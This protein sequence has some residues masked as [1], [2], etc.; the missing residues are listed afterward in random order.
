MYV[1]RASTR[2]C[3]SEKKRSTINVDS[4]AI[5]GS[6]KRNR[7]WITSA[8]LPYPTAIGR[9]NASCLPRT[10]RSRNMGLIS[11]VFSP[12]SIAFSTCVLNSLVKPARYSARN[13]A[14]VLRLCNVQSLPHRL[15]LN[16]SRFMNHL[17]QIIFF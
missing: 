16:R 2:R 9:R 11:A 7:V 12:S 10:A 4:V 6:R 13:H 3:W 15:L 5:G 17:L 8:G 14:I 1:T